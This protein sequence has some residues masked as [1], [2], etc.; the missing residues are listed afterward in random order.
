[1]VIQ[2][3]RL[4]NCSPQCFHSYIHTYTL[5]DHSLEG[6]FQGQWKQI[7]IEQK[8]VK[9]P[10]WWE[11]DQLAIYKYGGVEFG[12]TEDKSIQWQGAGFE[13]VT[14]GL[15]VRRPTTRPRL[16]PL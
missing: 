8:F 9:N 15:Q 7:Q 5:L 13:P 10:S 16:P 3:Y 6:A 11:A 12:T 4:T 1:M 14:S 2:S